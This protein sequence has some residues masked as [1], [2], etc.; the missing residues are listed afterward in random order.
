MLAYF[1]LLMVAMA[2]FIPWSRRWHGAFLSVAFGLLTVA[3]FSSL[4]SQLDTQF[5][6]DALM[7]GL[8]ALVASAA[9]HHMLRRTRLRAFASEAQLR[10]LHE[11][12]RRQQAELTRLNAE[13]EV[14]SRRDPLT[15][16]ATASGWKRTSRPSAVTWSGSGHRCPGARRRG[17]LQEVQ[18]L[19][20]ASRG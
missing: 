15:G 8:A 7:G 5:R 20:R 12:G 3:V 17:P 10:G 18:R 11:R 13:L 14:V 19:L 1:S 9:G 6:A 4:G 16:W 2:L